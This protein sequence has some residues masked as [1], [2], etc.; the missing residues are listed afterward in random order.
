VT[1]P[2][3]SSWCEVSAVALHGNIAA[4][5][6]VLA[7]GALLGIVVKSDAYGHGLELC[8]REFID[9]GADWLIVNSLGEAERLR[10]DDIDAPL[11]ICAQVAPFL[12]ERVAAVDARV[13]V[14]DADVAQAL[15]SAGRQRGRPVKMHLK[16]ETGTHRQGLAAAAVG[17]FV[18]FIAGLKG[19]ELEGLT[20]HFSTTDQAAVQEQLQVLEQVGREMAAIGVGVPMLHAAN[21]AATLLWPETHGALARVGIAAYGLWPS[22]EVYTALRQRCAEGGVMPQLCPALTWKARITQVKEVEE[23]GFVGY[24]R[25]FCATQRMRIGIVPVG[26]HEGYDRRLSNCG[27]VLVNGVRAPICGQICMNMFMVDL[28]HL[29]HVI[30]GQVATLLGKEGAEVVGADQWAEWMGSINYEVVT[31][32]HPGQPRF[33]R[34]ANGELKRYGDRSMQ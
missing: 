18:Q 20:T 1:E 25:T 5:R 30:A 22:R 8:A 26:Y 23:G 13:L 27:H 2:A 16:V 34:A 33:L 31:R 32:I 29:P 10:A 17:E 24:G 11:Y 14:C 21:S 15:A 4:L 19:A 12:A 7:P 28:T 6:A 9:A 3:L